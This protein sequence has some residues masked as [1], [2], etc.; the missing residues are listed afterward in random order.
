MGWIIQPTVGLGRSSSAALT[1][2]N[3]NNN[4]FGYAVLNEH[5]EMNALILIY[6]HGGH[7]FNDLNNPMDVTLNH[8]LNIE[9]LNWFGNLYHLHNVAPTTEQANEAFGTGNQ[10]LHRGILQG[11][12]GMWTGDFSER[13]GRSWAVRWENI[14]WG[15]V[16]MPR[17][18]LQL[19]ADWNWLRNFCTN[20]K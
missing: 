20:G 9:A 2:R 19:P 4:Q 5:L 6:Q 11:D 3:E 18:E 14:S 10:T 13:D 15:M 8:P 17:D 1:M 12:I 16:A 7:L